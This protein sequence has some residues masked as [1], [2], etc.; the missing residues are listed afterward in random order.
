MLYVIPRYEEMVDFFKTESINK[1]LYREGEKI[2]GEAQKLA[3]DLNLQ[4]KAI[5]QEGHA[6]DKIVEIA[7]KL[8]SDLIVMATHGWR[9][10][11]KAILG[12]TTERIIA[13]A[14]CPVLIVK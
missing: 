8:K 11:N 5:V 3:A 14:N 6:G 9:G 2:A 4:I 7:D 13:H 10:V 1:S 12:S